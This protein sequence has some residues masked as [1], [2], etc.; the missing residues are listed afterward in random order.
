MPEYDPSGNWNPSFHVKADILNLFFC[1]IARKIEFIVN[2]KI[3]KSNIFIHILFKFILYERSSN[4]MR[5]SD[6]LLFPEFINL[7][8][9]LLYNFIEFNVLLYTFLCNIFFSVQRAYDLTYF[10]LSCITC[11]CITC[12]YLCKCYW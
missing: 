2:A 9:I 8:S 1:M 10:L 7:V 11:R 6:V 12:F 3:S 4:I 5:G